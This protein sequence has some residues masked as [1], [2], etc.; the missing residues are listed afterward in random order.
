[1]SAADAK[2]PKLPY[3][4]RSLTPEDAALIGDI[5]PKV[6]ATEAS[7]AAVTASGKV[8]S[9][10]AWNGAQTWEERNCTNWGKEKLP[11][12]IANDLTTSGSGFNVKFTK[13]DKIDGNSSIT[14]S[15]GKARYLYEWTLT[16]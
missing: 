6:I 2:G 3:F 1:M 16:V 8:T 11:D 12:I 15:R 13:L 14:H 9:S 7:P 5:R 10:S 4:H